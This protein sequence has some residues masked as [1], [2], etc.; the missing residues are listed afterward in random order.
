MMLRAG[1]C[2]AVVYSMTAIVQNPFQLLLVRLLHGVGAGFIPAFMALA[3]TVSPSGKVGWSLG[4]MQMGVMTGNIAGPLL[5]GTLAML[6]GMRTSFVVAAIM[7]FV[8]SLVAG[9][10][11]KEKATQNRTSSPIFEDLRMVA[12]NGSIVRMLIV[13]IVLHCCLNLI[14]PFLSLHIV[15]LQGTIEGAALTSGVFLALTGLAGVIASPM[16]G[17][18]GE[19]AGFRMILIVCLIGSG[20]F[21]A[22]QFFC[23]STLVV[24]FDPIIFGL[25]M[26]G[27]A[28]SANTMIVRSS[29]TTF[30]GRAFGMSASATQLGALVGPL[31][32]S[33]LGMFWSTHWLFVAAGFLLIMT[34][35]IVNLEKRV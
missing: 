32:R 19:R 23:A 9:L 12:R 25:F 27:I 6:F 17:H 15:Y 20:V 4:M 21:I 2:L 10:W 7:I 5:G 3:A 26:A 14:Q 24:C 29:S 22:F 8:A 16:W 28:P 33:G 30:R 1:I 18:I 11:V 13:L 35:L 34:T 31:L